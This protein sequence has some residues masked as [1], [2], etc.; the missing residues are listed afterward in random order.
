MTLCFANLREKSRKRGGEAIDARKAKKDTSMRRDDAQAVG[1]DATGCVEE[2]RRMEA[3]NLSAG[4]VSSKI[5]SCG[6][7]V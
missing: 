2:K 4:K 3:G 5:G 7:E 6:P 1:R